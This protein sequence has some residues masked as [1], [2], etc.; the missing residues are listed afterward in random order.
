MKRIVVILVALAAAFGASAVVGNLLGDD[1]SAEERVDDYLTGTEERE[2]V[3]AE[4]QF[5]AVFPG[6]PERSTETSEVG[7]RTIPITFFAKELGDAAF[8][9][10]VFDV[11]AGAP[12][13]LDAAVNGSAA[14]V[15][16]KV[17]S[18]SRLK[19]QE[20]DAAEFVLSAGEGMFVK[21]MVI[22]A[23]ARVYQIQVVGND[24]PPRG[25]D[26]FKASFRIT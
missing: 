23:P 24:N 12:F 18:S 13:D 22:R 21:G 8:A 26:K 4:A 6:A 7:G 5:R 20:F 3:S 2:Y 11:P 9:V 16:G 10:A 14:A 17:E 19:F 1:E 25:Y 15:E